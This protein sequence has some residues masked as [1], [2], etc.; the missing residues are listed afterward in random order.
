MFF[1]DLNLLTIERSRIL[2]RFPNKGGSLM[3]VQK[4]SAVNRNNKLNKNKN[5][6]KYERSKFDFESER[7]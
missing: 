1:C 6:N 4:C 3:R 7:F 5:K 2:Y